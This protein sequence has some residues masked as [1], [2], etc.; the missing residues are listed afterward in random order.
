MS[1]GYL[2]TKAFEMKPLSQYH[3]HKAKIKEVPGLIPAEHLMLE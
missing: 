1:Y 2:Q 3:L